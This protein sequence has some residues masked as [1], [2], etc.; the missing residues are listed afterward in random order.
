MPFARIDLIKGRAAEYRHYH[1]LAGDLHAR[2]G[3]RRQD[4]FVSLIGSG[5]DDWSSGNGEVSRVK[6]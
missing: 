3:L 5:R 2:L 1:Q 6:S 4:V